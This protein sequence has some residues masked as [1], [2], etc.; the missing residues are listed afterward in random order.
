ML[1]CKF[2]QNPS[3]GLQDIA[4]E[5]LISTFFMDSWPW[6]LGQGHQNLINSEPPPNN[7]SVQVWSKSINWF[8]KYCAGKTNFNSF[9]GLVTLKIRSRSS[10]GSK[11]IASER[12]YA[13][14]EAD[15]IRTKNNM[16][17]TFG[18]G[19]I[20]VPFVKWISL[21]ELYNGKIQFPRGS[22]W[23]KQKGP[24]ILYNFSSTDTEDW[25]LS[26]FFTLAKSFDWLIW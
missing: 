3:I 11:D 20:I 12:S 23:V 5:R 21:S 25:I 6:K 26:F 16:S 19:D 14:A 17:P 24:K 4:L 13:E 8:T 9:Y 2:G 18:W 15:G 1:L 7:A 22:F 10:T